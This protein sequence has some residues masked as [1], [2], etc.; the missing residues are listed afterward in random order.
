MTGGVTAKDSENMLGMA[1]VRRTSN[2]LPT[3]LSV[4]KE[5]LEKMLGMPSVSSLFA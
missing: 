4:E 1:L 3:A 5:D 2:H